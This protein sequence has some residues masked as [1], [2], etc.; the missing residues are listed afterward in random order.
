MKKTL[1]KCA[2]KGGAHLQCMINHYGK[3]E[4]KGMETV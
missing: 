3:F 2:Q 1:M 4:Y